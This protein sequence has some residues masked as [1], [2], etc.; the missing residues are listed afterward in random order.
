MGNG[1]SHLKL[2]RVPRV[3]SKLTP[4]TPLWEIVAEQL[5]RGLRPAQIE[6]TLA[7]MP[8][9]VQFSRETIYTALYAMPRGQLRASLLEHMRRRHRQNDPHKE[10]TKIRSLPFQIRL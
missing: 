5:R 6:R 4:G 3:V 2:A 1:Y 10:K 8:E 9:P 7:R